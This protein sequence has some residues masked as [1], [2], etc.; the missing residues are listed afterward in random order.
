MKANRK[1]LHGDED[2]VSPVIAVILMVAITVVLAATV[3]VWVSGF[4]TNN[5]APAKTIALASNGALSGG[6]K[7]Y[8]VAS[9]SPGLRWS[10]M[11]FTLGGTPL[12]I[13]D[14]ADPCLTATADLGS[15]EYM[16]CTGARVAETGTAVVNAGDI[17]RF[18][19][20][21]G[22]T[23]RVLDGNSNSII[24]TITVS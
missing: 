23:L 16:P 8:V 24:L 20:A 19:A 13:S 12:A 5:S 2:A 14:A 7:E 17:L 3:Y 18:E 15:N 11:S 10:D 22:D 21:S 9:A 6:V 1:F 4:G